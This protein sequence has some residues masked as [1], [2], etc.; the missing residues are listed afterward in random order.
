MR[1]LHP[2][3][4]ASL[5]IKTCRQQSSGV[6]SAISH[7]GSSFHAS[8]L[9]QKI[10]SG[11]SRAAASKNNPL[12]WFSGGHTHQYPCCDDDESA[13]VTPSA[14]VTASSDAG[15]ASVGSSIDDSALKGTPR[16]APG[17]VT[18][19]ESRCKAADM[20][21]EWVNQARSQEPC[22]TTLIAYKQSNFAQCRACI[23]YVLAVTRI[24][25]QDLA[26]L[27]SSTHVVWHCCI[28]NDNS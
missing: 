6:L 17:H 21:R 7:A 15:V 26:V 28:R 9:M 24:L 1:K 20:C 12:H 18:F 22:S 19:G 16:R 23:C 4:S 2:T 27:S 11:I 5:L 13:P 3:V 8:P 25:A 10:G 14:A